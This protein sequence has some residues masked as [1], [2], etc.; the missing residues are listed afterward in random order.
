MIKKIT[1]LIIMLFV[2]TAPFYEYVLCSS[3]AT[4]KGI[5]RDLWIL[6][7]GTILALP[8]LTSFF[9]KKEKQMIYYV[10]ITYTVLAIGE[11]TF[12]MLFASLY[13]P[14]LG[15]KRYII[16]R[17][18]VMV[19]KGLLVILSFLLCEYQYEE[20]SLIERIIIKRR[21]RRVRKTK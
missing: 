10:F 16:I 18:A 4:G 11:F 19:I 15:A 13:I 8:L 3:A 7:N 20:N 5:N 21:L 9:I 2:T 12:E 14:E 1:M 6:V 17:M